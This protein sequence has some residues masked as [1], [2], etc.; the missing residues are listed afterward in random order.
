MFRRVGKKAISNYWLRYVCPSVCQY[1]RLSICKSAA[2]AG[3]ICVKFDNGHLYEICRGIPSF[4]KFGQK[5]QTPDKKTE[6]CFIVS[7]VAQQYTEGITML[8]QQQFQYL[9]LCWQWQVYVKNVAC[10]WQQLLH[11]RAILSC[12]THIAYFVK[13]WTEAIS[14]SETWNGSK[15][16]ES[17]HKSN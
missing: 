11:E 4:V 2:T 1:V 15:E 17:I 9:L 16:E 6:V 14:W 12:Y 3:R 8:S 5:H 10:P 13:M 7:S